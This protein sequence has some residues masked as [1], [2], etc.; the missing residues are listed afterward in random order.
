[1]K[2]S[3]RRLSTSLAA[4]L[5]FAG[6]PAAVLAHAYDDDGLLSGMVFTSS[7]AQAGNE[8][9]VYARAPDG[10]LSPYRQAATGGQGS[11]V[12]L[13]SQGAVT[14][15][16][17]GRYVFVVNAQSNTV[18][19]FELR[20]R[21]LVMVSE[22]PSGGQHPISVA[23]YNNVVYVLNDQGVA[24]VSGLRNRQGMLEPITGSSRP[25]SVATGAA[26]AQVSFS[27]DG[28]AL[29]VTEKATNK[30]TSYR[31]SG[32]M[33]SAAPTVTAS[34][35]QTPFGFAFSRHNRLL[36]TEAVGGAPGASTVSSYRFTTDE[37]ARPQ[38]VSASVPDT[39]TA[40]CWIA[41]TPDGRFAYVANTG[42]SSVSSY[43]IANNGQIELVDAVAARTGAGSAPADTSVSTDGLHL[44]VR[45]GL[46][47]TIS[48]FAIGKYGQLLRGSR[49]GALPASAVGLAAN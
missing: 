5:M 14:L 20:N 16:R 43:R 4:V 10:T 18:S 8:L 9:L 48:A 12:G 27:D 47:S 15:S 46:T 34:P 39:Q 38:L 44:Y 30:L 45:S 33:L 22:V 31:V 13:G 49:V 37:P 6:L 42:S 26:P 23:E 1:M 21:E 35:G 2:L 28:D 7:N 17:N 36:V 19:A 3:R 24:N 25:L 29:L 11:G 40:A 32:A 41:I